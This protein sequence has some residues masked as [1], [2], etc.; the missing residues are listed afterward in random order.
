MRTPVIA[1]AALLC[2]CSGAAT[3]AADS[4]QTSGAT[5]GFVDEFDGQV[6][7]RAKWTVYTGPVYNSE[8][9]AYVDDSANVYIAHGAEAGGAVGGAL[10]LRAH[11]R[12]GGVVGT[13]QSDF[14]S[15]R[16]HGR[17]LFSF[18]TATARMKL[19]AGSGL[20][21]AFW[22]LGAGEWPANGE[23][24]VMEN[25]GD[26]TWVSVALH[27]PGYS[28][29]T[30]LLARATLPTSRDATAWH[31]YAVTWTADSIV[32]RVDGAVVYR[33]TRAQVS[34]L[35]DAAALDRPKYVV[36]NL[37]LGGEYPATV[38]G[39]RTP[40]LGLPEA[41]IPRIQRGEAKVLVDWV[42]MTQ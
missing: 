41:T 14:T 21:P 5:T 6:L 15:A 37:A 31:E 2:G 7:D 20:W 9:Q 28:G 30:P 17:T 24:D 4:G 1:F 25:V 22:L 11:Y 12:P 23:I 19:P 39:A 8:L 3:I 34:A 40:Y 35:G 26:S 10:M 38:N 16:I 13:R 36:L 29:N 32:F 33:V 42:R 27:G 18:G